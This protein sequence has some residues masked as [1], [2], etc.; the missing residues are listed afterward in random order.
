MRMEYPVVLTPDEN[1]TIIV[2]F[3]DI[4]EAITMGENA[5]DALHWAQDALV[6]ALSGY[7]D[8]GKPVPAP[9][10]PRRGQRTVS[11]P[12]QVAAK[13]AIHNAMIVQGVTGVELAKRMKCD[14]KQ[15]RRILDLDHNSKMDQL[16]GA[17]RALGKTLVVEVHD[18]ALA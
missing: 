11:V 4:P 10:K 9:T 7:L 17:L 3:R 13:I 12:P 2:Q 18:L 5:T 1:G 15:V 6:V 14:E 16:E 8:C